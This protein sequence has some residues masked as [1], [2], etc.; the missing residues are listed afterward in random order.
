LYDVYGT[1]ISPVDTDGDGVP[2]YL[3]LDSDND[4]I[5][6]LEESATLSTP[7]TTVLSTAARRFCLNGLI[8]S[9]ENTPDSEY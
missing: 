1:G 4:G 7:I 5:Y 6:D 2:D 9:L 8:D 3:D